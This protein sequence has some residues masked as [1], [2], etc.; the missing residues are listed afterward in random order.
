MV[1][2]MAGFD[3]ELRSQ[4]LEQRGRRVDQHRLAFGCGTTLA[5]K[6][7][8]LSRNSFCPRSANVSIEVPEI[9]T[10]EPSLN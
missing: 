9:I 10:V 3:V 6:M 4:D 2:A 8:S 1:E 7:P 5:E